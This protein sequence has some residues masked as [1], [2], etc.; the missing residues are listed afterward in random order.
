MSDVKKEFVHLLANY[1]HIG[2]TFVS[3]ILIGLGGGIYL[4]QK[5]FDGQTAPWLTFVG[6]AFGIAAGY[7]SLLE[8]VWRNR[9]DEEKAKA[10]EEQT[11]KEQ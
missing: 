9:R 4:D 8:V 5:V 7:K 6:L 2:F 10:K 11:G 1:G 3:A